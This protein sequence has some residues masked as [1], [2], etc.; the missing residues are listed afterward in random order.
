M[1]TA[2]VVDAGLA[3]SR[4]RAR[5]GWRAIGSSPS[6]RRVRRHVVGLIADTH[7]HLDARVLRLFAGVG[8][9]LHA[10]DVGDEAVLAALALLAPVRAVLGN[11]D[12]GVL[13]GRYPLHLV[14]RVGAVRLLLLHEVGRPEAPPPAVR[15]LLQRVRPHAVC[16]GHTHRPY[17]AVHEGILFLNPGAAGPSRFG[18]PRSVARLTVTGEKLAAEILS[19]P[20]GRACT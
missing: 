6:R 20:A 2:V 5:P 3:D 10:G 18:L 16:F 1:A 12:R 17:R 8:L 11:A 13:D 14:E 4:A 7:G 15:A 9:I 19:L